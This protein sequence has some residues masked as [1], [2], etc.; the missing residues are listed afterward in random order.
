MKNLLKRLISPN[1]KGQRQK[2]QKAEF[3]KEEGVN[4]EDSCTSCGSCCFI[5]TEVGEKTVFKACKHLSRKDGVYYCR[6]YSRRLGTIVGQYKGEAIRCSM[7]NSLDAEIE[8][9]PLNVGGK[10]TY[11]VTINGNEANFKLKDEG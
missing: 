5:P 7:Y 10:P 9:C 1:V 6:I 2:I 8:G 4:S 11:E 3:T